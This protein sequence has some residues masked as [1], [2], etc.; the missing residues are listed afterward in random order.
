MATNL[1][2]RPQAEAALKSEAVR[3]GRSQQDI[4]R[5]AIDSYLAEQ[6]RDGAVSVELL[7]PPR[8]PLTRPARRI[9]L[10]KPLTSGDLLDR[11]DRI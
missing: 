9:R 2:L 11:D 10:P 3:S 8:I 7:A 6:A 1:R 5:A 4:I